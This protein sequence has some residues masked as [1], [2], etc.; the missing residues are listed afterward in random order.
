ML[1]HSSRSPHE[2]LFFPLLRSA[3]LAQSG[4]IAG[5][6]A[7]P[8]RGPLL[9]RHSPGLTQSQ[10]TL[11]RGCA[12]WLSLLFPQSV[13]LLNPPYQRKGHSQRQ[14]LKPRTFS[15]P[16]F[17]LSQPAGLREL[18][19]NVT[20]PVCMKTRPLPGAPPSWGCDSGQW[21]QAEKG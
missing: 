8:E 17:F 10:S 11:V 7:A 21:D 16:R 4:K 15:A 5:W 6:P 2:P 18:R 13:S 9:P 3:L 1:T 19:W 14:R 20:S 12:T